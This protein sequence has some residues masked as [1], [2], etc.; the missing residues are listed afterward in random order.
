[1]Q[2]YNWKLEKDNILLML[3]SSWTNP[4]GSSIFGFLFFQNEATN[5]IFMDL[6]SRVLKSGF[7]MIRDSRIWIFKDSFCGVVLK[8]HDDSLDLWKQVESL[9]VRIRDPWIDT[10]P[11][12]H[13]SQIQITQ[14]YILDITL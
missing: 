8:V 3:W 2:S 5:L 6:H 1:M 13:N 4:Y 11:R 9:K 7:V 14:P 10:N 12:V